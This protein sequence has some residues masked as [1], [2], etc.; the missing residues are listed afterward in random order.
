MVFDIQTAENMYTW[1]WEQTFWEQ[2]VVRLPLRT[3][4]QRGLDPVQFLVDYLRDKPEEVRRKQEL[5]RSR[6]FELQYSLDGPHEV[7]PMRNMIHNHKNTSDNAYN[8]QVYSS[9]FP[10]SKHFHNNTWPLCGKG[11]NMTDLAPC[12]DAY[13]IIMELSMGF[14]SKTGVPDV[15]VGS[16]LAC[17]DGKLDVTLNKCVMPA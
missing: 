17:W 10:S 4:G 5:L 3:V 11:T 8:N 9:H 14:H 16:T 2:V 6:V 12:R 7:P 1:H 13:D 15:R